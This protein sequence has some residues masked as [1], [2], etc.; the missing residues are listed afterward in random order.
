V[1][2][3]ADFWSAY[4]GMPPSSSSE[5]LQRGVVESHG[6]SVQPELNFGASDFSEYWQ[7]P[8]FDPPPAASQVAE[9]PPSGKGK[10]LGINKLLPILPAS[11]AE[12]PNFSSTYVTAS[13][14]H[15]T[16]LT[17]TCSRSEDGAKTVQAALMNYAGGKL[18]Q[19]VMSG[20]W[21][22]CTEDCKQDS[23]V[24][25]SARR[26]QP[27]RK[28]AKGSRSGFVFVFLLGAVSALI[29]FLLLRGTWRI[30]QTMYNV[31][32]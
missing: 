1:L 2:L 24:Q 29:W 5:E 8:D 14:T 12:L 21:K 26:Q 15:V 27:Q 20:T 30:A 22:P 9:K 6:G 25:C 19:E 16:A 4:E 18:H 32:L 31:I 3:C 11:A 7:M 23:C 13:E 17:I 10:L 28:V